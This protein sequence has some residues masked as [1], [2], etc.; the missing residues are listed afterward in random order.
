MFLERGGDC[1]HKGGGG[2]DPPSP[3]K[4]MSRKGNMRGRAAI[5]IRG[6][7]DLLMTN[8]GNTADMC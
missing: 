1:C 4:D 5:Q 3:D 7:L 2:E 8:N 6:G